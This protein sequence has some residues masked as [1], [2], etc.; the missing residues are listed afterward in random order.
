MK[1]NTN[2]SAIISNKELNKTQ[3]NLRKSLERLSSGYKL[4]HAKDDTAGIAIS[5]RIK[6]QIR[7]LDK[8]GQNASDGM[9]V[10]DTAEG[11][12]D[13]IHQ[14]LQR[15]NELA[16]QAANDTNTNTDRAAIQSEINA[17][18]KEIDRVSK[19]TEFNMQNLLDGN[20][21][22]RA[23][24]DTDGVSVSYMST[25]MPVG[26]YQFSVTE[27][28][29]HAEYTGG[30]IDTGAF[31]AGVTEEM[32]GVIT[33]NDY[34]LNVPKGAT[35][36]EVKNIIQE[37]ANNTNALLDV[38]DPS[39]ISISSKAYGDNATV[40]IGG[41]ENLLAA[42]GM[43][44]TEVSG[45]DVKVNLV[46]GEPSF[47]ES[48]TYTTDG[49]LVNVK[50]KNGFELR[51]FVEGGTESSTATL[52][53]TNY[54]M[55]SV[56]VGANENQEIMVDLPEVTTKTLGLE[57]LNVM[58]FALASD[59]INKIGQALDFVSLTR[60]R[61]GA[62]QNRM[63]YSKSNIDVSS[64]NLTSALSVIMDVDM[65]EEM[66]EYTQ[67]NILS[68]AGISML[69]QANERPENVLQLLQ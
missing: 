31:A 26:K 17:L 21:S 52:D 12:L 60:S 35:L 28:P 37:A 33:I 40:K 53:V 9:S 32:A 69:S 29:K 30:A 34:T 23:Y 39:K 64:E 57:N 15:M 10:L 44:A 54:G 51:F 1:I 14:I 59:G 11:A 47:D 3:G 18:S 49:N 27:D 45:S 2:I 13:A 61:L 66:T 50:A 58:T 68:Q 38:S 25:D 4:N 46:T 48:A 16:V 63:E 20:L 65:A 62:Y 55:M 6:S 19:D 43:S 42:L 36:D 56:H 67:Q 22:R 24:S 7:G 8:A 5:N 41:N